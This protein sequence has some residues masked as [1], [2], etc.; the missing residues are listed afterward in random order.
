MAGREGQLPLDA[1]R[2]KD[3]GTFKGKRSRL[4]GKEMAFLAKAGVMWFGRLF[5]MI[6]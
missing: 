2:R 3:A 4:D 6:I 1:L 5:G